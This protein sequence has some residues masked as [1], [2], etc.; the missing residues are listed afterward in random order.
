MKITILGIAVFLVVIIAFFGW[1][2]APWTLPDGDSYVV[3]HG[4][5]RAW[6]S[7]SILFVAGAGTACF[8]DKQYGLFPPTSL[9]WLFIV[10]GAFIMVV[11]AA[12]MHL[13]MTSWAHGV[14]DSAVIL[15]RRV[16]S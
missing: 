10:L 13:I 6:L 11:S 1:L 7:C 15:E 14:R 4:L 16:L 2:A 3:H 8:A 12:L 9:R 5:V